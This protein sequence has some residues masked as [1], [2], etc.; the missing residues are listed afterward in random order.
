MKK[1]IALVLAVAAMGTMGLVSCGGGESSQQPSV[2]S[3]EVVYVEDIQLE[4]ADIAVNINETVKI[5]ATV[6]PANVST[7]GVTYSSAN[8]E[9]A[10]VSN[11]GVVTGKAAGET[12]ITVTSK[13]TKAD[14]QPLSKQVHVKVNEVFVESLS[15]ASESVRLQVNGTE[16]IQATILPANASNLELEYSSADASVATVSTGGLIKGIKVGSTTVKV[17]TKGKTKDGASL[18]KTISVEVVATALAELKIAQPTV[19]FNITDDNPSPTAMIEYEVL[20]SNA[21]EKGV[22]FQS[23]DSD[24]ATVSDAGM[25]TAVGV[26]E[27]KIKLTTVGVDASG[28]H[29]EGEVAVIVTSKVLVVEFRNADGTLLKGYSADDI[30]EGEV[31]D[32]DGDIPG[33][34]SDETNIYI[35]RGFDKAIVPYN[36]SAG[37]VIY[38]AVYE[39]TDSTPRMVTL[40]KEEQDGKE[41]P[42][43]TVSGEAKGVDT[44]TIRNRAWIAFQEHT[45]NNWATH[46]SEPRAPIINADGTWT[47]QMV[48]D[49][50]T[51]ATGSTFMGKYV[52][53]KDEAKSPVDL[54]ILHRENLLRYRHDPVTGE[55]L[56]DNQISDEW[57][58]ILPEDYVA[59]G[60]WGGG[61]ST[62]LNEEARQ[63]FAD[64]VPAPTWVGLGVSY[65]PAKFEINGKFWELFTDSSVWFLPSVR[66]SDFAT[67]KE[68]HLAAEDDAVYY[69]VSG[70]LAAEGIADEA[71]LKKA[72]MDFEHNGSV[73]G[74]SG[75]L[76]P[77][78]G[79][80]GPGL[81]PSKVTISGTD[82]TLFFR[83]DNMEGVKDNDLNGYYPHFAM[84]DVSTSGERADFRSSVKRTS[85]ESV[86]VGGW[87]YT[88]LSGNNAAG[89]WNNPGLQVERYVEAISNVSEMSYSLN[90]GKPFL[91]LKGQVK[92][93][94]GAAKIRV[95]TAEADVT[96][97]LD[98]SFD[99]SIDVSGLAV[100]TT[101]SF[102]GNLAYDIDIIKDEVAHPLKSADAALDDV[103]VSEISMNTS[104]ANVNYVFVNKGGRFRMTT[105]A[106][107]WTSS[108]L[109]LREKEGKAMLRVVGVLQNGISRDG[110]SLAINDTNNDNLFKVALPS[111]GVSADGALD[112]EVDITGF[113]PGNGN[114]RVLLIN[115]QGRTAFNNDGRGINWTWMND[116]SLG[117]NDYGP[118]NVGGKTYSLTSDN[119]AVVR[120]A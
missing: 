104:G 44:E 75:F 40:T 25:I 30:T 17:K 117:L 106:S 14:G 10:S 83:V 51:Y 58:G 29:L 66:T 78:S 73:D 15:V 38:T 86:T 5:T 103:K 12:T 43:F 84:S 19:Q 116:W 102:D 37:K 24:V 33:K 82:F 80:S 59:T 32:Y 101:K 87:L 119:N 45:T 76:A 110:L 55:V 27:T 67:A 13:G 115:S 118:V 46:Y 120:V 65:E 16:Q 111:G 99:A 1:K 63:R 92:G 71:T 35:F 49:A 70:E 85:G 23:L 68:I 52:W 60:N 97:G 94:S 31:P 8:P 69:T 4:S 20:P 112:F 41:V 54:K 42:V 62:N 26:G 72:S 77:A 36:A 53:N 61:T 91:N 50:E 100:N 7:R 18:E 95:G 90:D 93:L 3:R 79:K 11:S 48:L 89:Y 64:A 28:N 21:S 22:T 109:Q 107:A 56:E 34:A 108:R 39:A 2:S 57:D 81:N 9:I 113:V 96:L 114:N 105:V 47:M 74:G 6:L 98:G 88:I